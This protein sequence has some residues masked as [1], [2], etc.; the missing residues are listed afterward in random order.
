[1]FLILSIGDVL[2][3]NKMSEIMFKKVKSVLLALFMM[4]VDTVGYKL[5]VLLV[6]FSLSYCGV[7]ID[8]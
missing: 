5:V 7:P 8:A 2:K 1:M 6:V 3:M 4:R